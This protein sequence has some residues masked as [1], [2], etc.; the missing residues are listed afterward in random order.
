MSRFCLYFE[1]ISVLELRQ[2]LFLYNKNQRTNSLSV[3][4]YISVFG[5]TINGQMCST[6]AESRCVYKQ[7]TFLFHRHSCFFALF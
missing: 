2:V 1:M 6:R 7:L 4:L 5:M 3:S